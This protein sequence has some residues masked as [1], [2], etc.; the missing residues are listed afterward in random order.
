M[1]P[2]QDPASGAASSLAPPPDLL[3]HVQE[4]K[5][6]KTRPESNKACD[7]FKDRRLTEVSVMY[8]RLTGEG[9]EALAGYAPRL[10]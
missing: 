5:L 10:G 3:R 2:D 1:V 7:P 4:R 8:V 6:E 9:A